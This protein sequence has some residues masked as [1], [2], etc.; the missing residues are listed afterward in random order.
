MKAQYC[1]CFNSYPFCWCADEFLSVSIRDLCFERLSWP[2][3]IVCFLEN[4]WCVVDQWWQILKE[5]AISVLTQLVRCKRYEDIKNSSTWV[6]RQ[7]N[8]TCITILNETRDGVNI[9]WK[10]FTWICPSTDICWLVPPLCPTVGNNLICGDVEED[11]FGCS[12][13]VVK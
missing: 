9:A 12:I 13:F 11:L 4:G 8:L 6:K 10:P 2:N 1:I 3:I 5:N 7:I